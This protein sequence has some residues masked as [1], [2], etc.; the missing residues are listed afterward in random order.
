MS[1]VRPERGS[2]DAR[3]PAVQSAN[4]GCVGRP[5]KVVCRRRRQTAVR[6]DANPQENRRLGA[7]FSQAGGN[8]SADALTA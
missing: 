2:D 3:L 1:Q 5:P 8:R 4:G 6:D 7:R